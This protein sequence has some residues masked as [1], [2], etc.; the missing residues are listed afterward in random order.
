MFNRL[1]GRKKALAGCFILFLSFI[2]LSACSGGESERSDSA[3]TPAPISILA[4]LHFSA[5]AFGGAD[6]R[7]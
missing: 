5:D 2:T 4:P 6:R 1:T 7:D 3:D